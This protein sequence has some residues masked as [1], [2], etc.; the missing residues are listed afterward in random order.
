MVGSERL[1]VLLE[2]LLARVYQQLAARAPLR[3]AD[4]CQ[5]AQRTPHAF[6]LDQSFVARLPEDCPTDAIVQAVLAM[7]GH[8]GAVVTTEGV[9]TEQ[10]LQRLR[11]L[12]CPQAQGFL[13]GRPITASQLE[14]D[15]L[16]IEA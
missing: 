7:A 9:E 3:G 10:Q 1:L 11:E 13:L 12:G 5:L 4:L 8:L 6:K 16:T 2:L 14:R 15:W